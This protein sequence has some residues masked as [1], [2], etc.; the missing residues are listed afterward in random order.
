MINL[1][2]NK[3]L[4]PVWLFI[5]GSSKALAQGSAL[6]PG[7]AVDLGTLDLLI[8]KLSLF[9]IRTSPVFAVIMIVYGGIVY[10]S[11][12]DNAPRVAK[13][14]AI[15]RNAIIGSLV[16]FGVGVIIQTIAGV[17]TG[18]FFCEVR[19]PIVGICIG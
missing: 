8:F 18:D 6:P 3:V 11:A 17:V 13:A 16:I 4:I 9:I 19:V 15:L 2:K 5:A 12:G 7:Q 10:A 14:K 1:L